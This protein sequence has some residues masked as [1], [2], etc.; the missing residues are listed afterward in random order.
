MSWLVILVALLLCLLGIGCLV[1]VVLGLPGGWIF[2]GVALGIEWLDRFYLPA[3]D[4]QTFSLWVLLAS[5]ALL[6][7]GEL[8]EF[9]AGVAGAKHGG[10]SRRGMIGAL[11]GGILGAFVLTPVFFFVPVLGA[12]FGALLGTFLG[13]VIGELT[14]ERETSVRGSLRPAVGATI[15][16][17][18][19]TVGKLGTSIVVWIALTVS[20]ALS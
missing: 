8:I 20:A 3:D 10:A 7:L 11:V 15:G 18:L 2:F 9:L 1:L 17:V 12:L 14:G 16:R 13:A 6:G 4:R 19:G 5:L